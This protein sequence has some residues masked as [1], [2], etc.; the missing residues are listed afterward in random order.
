MCELAPGSP[1][2]TIFA[3]PL[4]VAS[5]RISA[6]S[7]SHRGPYPI[8]ILRR[9]HFGRGALDDR[10]VYAHAGFERA[11]LLELLAQ[12]ERRGRQPYKAVERLAAKRVE[13]EMMEQRTLARGRTGAGEI[14]RAQATRRDRG[15]D[16]LDEIRIVAS[17][18]IADLRRRGGDVDARVKERPKRGRDRAR[19]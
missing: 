8:E 17:G 5:L 2:N 7:G 9:V 18:R 1:W 10:H 15:S 19:F 3:D 12:L 16:H 14:Q 11:E 4:I 13:P 6:S